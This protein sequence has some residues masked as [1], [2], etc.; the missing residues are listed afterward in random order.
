MKVIILLDY[1]KQLWLKNNYKE[2]S[3]DYKLLCKYLV[4]LCYDVSV[5]QYKDIDFYN[6]DYTNNYIIYQSSEDPGLYYKSYIE[7]ILLGLKKAGAILLP[8]YQFLRAHH[9]KVFMEIMR[10]NTKDKELNNIKSKEYG[11]YEECLNDIKMHNKYVF[12]LACGAQ[13][14][15]V[16][17]LKQMSDLKKIK[18]H[19][20]TYDFYYWIVDKIKP[21]LKNTYKAYK[22]K[23]H[24]RN[25]YI[26]QEYVEGLKGDYK[27]IVLNDKIYV[28]YRKNRK[29][30]FR[31]SG[32]GLFM[33][34]DVSNEMLEYA[35]YIYNLFDVP[36]ISLDIAES[37]NVYYVVEF[38]FVSFGTYTVERA[39]YY[40]EKQNNGWIKKSDNIVLEKEYAES[41]HKYIRRH[42]AYTIHS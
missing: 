21:F 39:P 15:N 41:F 7:D 32:S 26:I 4:E 31:A 5:L 10:K 37:N 8:D 40:Y 16:M 34:G 25:K 20:R 18:K 19:T 36:F 38:Q 35:L 33:Y 13:S 28:L 12:K 24:H 23:S 22:K 27:V 3:V 9:N 30:D 29:N 17:L 2:Q 1:R 14:K 42:Y 6:I 11:C